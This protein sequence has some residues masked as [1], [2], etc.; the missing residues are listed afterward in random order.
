MPHIPVSVGL[1]DLFKEIKLKSLWPRQ[2]LPDPLSSPHQ[3]HY[4]LFHLEQ[5]GLLLSAPTRKGM[6]PIP[7]PSPTG[8]ISAAN[9]P[10]SVS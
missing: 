1:Q 10:E 8:A 3:S 2:E 4:L 7:H 9:L 6:W 5:P